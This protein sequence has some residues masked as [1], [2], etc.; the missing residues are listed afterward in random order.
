M[1]LDNRIT[2]SQ[3]NFK[4]YTDFEEMLF[5]FLCHF[6]GHISIEITLMGVQLKK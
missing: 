3:G 2:I 4:F 6:I 5:L 1:N